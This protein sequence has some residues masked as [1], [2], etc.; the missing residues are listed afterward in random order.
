MAAPPTRAK[1]PKLGRRKS[2]SDTVGLP[3]GNNGVV[4]PGRGTRHSLGNYKDS[5]ATT[6]NDGRTGDC[7][8]FTNMY[9]EFRLIINDV[10]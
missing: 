4:A 6:T 2:C 8:A 5:S 7:Y 1:S 10:L 9:K 3:Q